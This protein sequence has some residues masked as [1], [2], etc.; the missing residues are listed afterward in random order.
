MTYE[1]LPAAVRE[2][3]P[4]VV[5]DLAGVT[6]AGMRTPEL[7]ALV[8]AWSCP[9][10]DTPIPGTR[11]RS[12]PETAAHLAA[13]GACCLELDEGNKYAAGHPAAH[14]YFAAVAATQ[15]ADRPV[16][17][18]QFLTVFALG[19]EVAARFGRATTIDRA[20][21]PH[22]NWGA[23]G[24]ACAAA[25][26]MGATPAE[27]AA[28][29]D[30]STAL[31]Q[32]TPWATA[33]A[34]D[35]T[36]N[37]WIAGANAAGLQAARL[38]LAGL[39]DNPG[40]THDS[41][42]GIL[43]TLDPDSL[44][45]DLGERWLVAEGY[46]KLHAACSYTHPAVDL[47]QALRASHAWQVDDVVSVRVRTHSLARP[48]LSRHPHNRLA[49]MFSLP[50]VVSTAVVNKTV[51]P[52]TMEPGSSAFVA[53]EEF[54]SRV[55]VEIDEQL[56][57]FLPDVRCTEVRIE[58]AGGDVLELA[59]PNPIG[60]AHYFP[61]DREAIRAKIAGLIGEPDTERIMAAVG[62]LRAAPDAKLVLRDLALG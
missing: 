53:A 35:F 48:L 54:S 10:G 21:H 24:A 11:V 46:V 29:I 37:L 1:E 32:V 38:S 42:G 44:V 30:A 27:V 13:V 55:Q 56:D 61:L 26:V 6:V 43:G 23:T 4:L 33:L 47:V 45:D 57:A 12:V 14:V 3:L 5:T 15:L 62:E 59:A 60:D 34:G 25:L 9:P 19:Y 18:E 2:R 16:S 39:V 28:A 22:G 58:L 51:D 8:A 20:W 31:M 50:F 49:A 52:Q 41:L 17:G 36:R 7:V 40:S